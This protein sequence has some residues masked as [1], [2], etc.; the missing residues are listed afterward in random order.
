MPIIR[1]Y[2]IWNNKGGVGKSTITYHIATRYA[3]RNPNE[4]VLVI[5]MCPQAN[6]SMMLLGGGNGD[7]NVLN[8]IN[9]VPSQTVV[10]YM[11]E[12]LANHNPSA[13]AFAVQVC[14]DNP[15]MPSNLYLLCGDGTLD[16]MAPVLQ[17]YSSQPSTSPTQ[18]DSWMRVR[19]LLKEFID[20]FVTERQNRN[21]TV[22]I[23]TNPAFSIY[24]EIAISAAERLICPVNADDS[25]RIAASAL[26]TLL[27]PAI[28]PHPLYSQYSYAAK[29]VQNGLNVPLIHLVVGN[30]MTQ[31]AGAAAAFSAMSNA[32]TSILYSSYVN[33]PGY[34]T[35]RTTTLQS[36]DD[37]INEY[38]HLL[39]DF[40][41][42]GVVTVYQGQLLSQMQQGRYVVHGRD[43]QLKND[44]I[45]E[46][47]QSV[48]DLIDKL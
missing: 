22:F 12:E 28:T 2:A 4:D 5:D 1:N 21:I 44:R 15:N 46:C 6:I 8:K 9:T 23:D 41:T 38:S 32:T 3:E 16:L 14:Q 18:I 36:A 13:S 25:S 39:R 42:T 35:A 33:S 47:L 40:N 34:F 48:D 10:G 24:T 17:Y 20:K 26:M 30:R 7:Q 11:G 27:H 31:Y 45:T 43:V 37:F 19:L 29:A